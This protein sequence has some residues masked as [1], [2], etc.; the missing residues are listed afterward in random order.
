MLAKTGALGS[1]AEVARRTCIFCGRSDRKITGEHVLGAWLSRLAGKGNYLA[2]RSAEG[3]LKN[4][5]ERTWQT[6]EIADLQI[7]DVCVVCNGAVSA[8]E[9]PAKTAIA[10]ILAGRP[11]T[12][13]VDD[14]HALA[15]WLY[16][17]ATLYRYMG[18]PPRTATRDE[19]DAVFHGVPLGGTKMWVAA[20]HGR[21]TTKLIS[22]QIGLVR[23]ASGSDFLK[24][25]KKREWDRGELVTLAVGPFAAQIALYPPHTNLTYGAEGSVVRQIWPSVGPTD[26]PPPMYFDDDGLDAF[27]QTV[28][29]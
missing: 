21:F 6:D 24:A 12:L 7:K 2:I 29:A 5:T 20:Y 1:R 26:W 11:K 14:Q 3:V 4:T 16:K 27:S 25:L 23:A 10:P 19:L 28:I 8:M 13:T 18:Q 22:Y 9:T 15:R 17:I